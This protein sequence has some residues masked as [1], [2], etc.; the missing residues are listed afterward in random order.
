MKGGSAV[1]ERYLKHD[2]FER[3]VHWVMA[4]SVIVL[5]LSGL[6]IRFPGFVPWGDMNSSRF[7]HFVSM[8]FLIFSWLAHI[9]HTI[10]FEF[11]DEIF[12]PSELRRIP[13][14][15][16]YYLFLTE[17]HPPYTKYNPLQK[18]FYNGLWLLIFIQVATG[19]LLY[20]P[21]PTMGASDALGGLMAV[22]ILHDFMTYIF[23]SF[24]IAHVYLVLVEDVR[25]LWAMFHGYYFRR[26]EQRG[27][28]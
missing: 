26:V 3:V 14:M 24:I 16:R 10:V 20:W 11:K 19:L 12:C 5:I 23:I 2:L 4:L 13:G 28:R 25:G 9:F 8:Y 15:I 17:E 22:R 7:L 18:L 1:E 27:E 6:N 21:A